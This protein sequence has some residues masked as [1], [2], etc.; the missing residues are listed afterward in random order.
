MR[1]RTRLFRPCSPKQE[2]RPGSSTVA[3]PP[4]GT[5]DA[6]SAPVEQDSLSVEG[7][8]HLHLRA[9]RRNEA[10]SPDPI[11]ASGAFARTALELARAREEFQVLGTRDTKTAS[12]LPW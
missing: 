2:S 7:R 4:T 3:A 6:A 10:A 9:S 1:R 5:L 8:P 11:G 12:D